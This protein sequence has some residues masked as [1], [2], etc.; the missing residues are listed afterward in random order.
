MKVREEIELSPGSRVVVRRVAGDLKLRSGEG[1]QLT[2]LSREEKLRVARDGQDIVIECKDDCRIRL[3]ADADVVIETVGGD[4]GISD[5]ERGT[6]IGNVGGDLS[7]RRCGSSLVRGVGGDL[8]AKDIQGDLSIKTVGGDCWIGRIGGQTRVE[9]VGGDGSFN[10]LG[11]SLRAMVGGDATVNLLD[12]IH[13]SVNVNAGGDLA[14]RLSKG[15]S[16]RV[17]LSAGADIRSRIEEVATIG[18]RSGSF[19]LGEGDRD[20]N[21]SAGGSLWIGHEIEGPAVG[22]DSL[23]ADLAS[24]IEGM[25][26]EA[27]ASLAALGEESLELDSEG[28]GERV[29]RIVDRA[30]RRGTQTERMAAVESALANQMG[31]YHQ[32][33]VSDEERLHVLRMVEEKKITIEEA[34]KLLDAL[35]GSS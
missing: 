1:R 7:L 19:V 33:P 15:A 13:G 12:G 21:L 16:V 14:C 31:E 29:R 11:G 25:M 18:G 26:V 4:A 32:D 2:V 10:R 8:L 23:G 3:P 34:E 28:I 6:E 20:I 5:L 35:G 17:N 22:L 9:A 27:E 30:V 24:K